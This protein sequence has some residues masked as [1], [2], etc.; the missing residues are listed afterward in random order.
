MNALSLQD[1]H[2][3][4]PGRDRPD[5]IAGC[6]TRFSAGVHLL[7]GPSGCGKSTLLRLL[8]GYLTPRRGRIEAADAGAVTGRDYQ[9]RRMGFV[10]QSLNLLD[11]ASV[12][13]NVE[14]AGLLAGLDHRTAATRTR[15]WLERLGIGALAD[16][17][18]D[19]ISGG[20]RQRAALAR[21]LV[22]APDIVLLD[23]P[24]SG[25]DE[26]NTQVLAEA[27]RAYQREAADRRI[28]VI[29]AHDDRLVPAADQRWR[30]VGGR[31]EG[32]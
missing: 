14:M 20:Q 7:R 15:A 29:A 1:V 28:V 10:F 18:P 16:S 25:L 13:Q 26:A 5:V 27:L 11:L 4:Y 12:R 24:T 19:R 6:T 21:A 8:A 17:R 9:L 22:K 23:E 2:F 32:A 31:P 3:A 30:F